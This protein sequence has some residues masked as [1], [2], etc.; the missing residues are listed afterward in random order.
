MTTHQHFRPTGG[1]ARIVSTPEKREY[2]LAQFL[3][4]EPATVPKVLTGELR[5]SNTTI[6]NQNG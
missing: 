4:E 2:L 3:G 1:L 5:R 6:R